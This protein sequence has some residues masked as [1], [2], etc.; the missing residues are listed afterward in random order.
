[1]A[2]LLDFIFGSGALKQAAQTGNP[3]AQQT[4][5]NPPSGSGNA[6]IDMAS[7]AQQQADRSLPKKKKALPA[8]TP[9]STLQK[10]LM[11]Q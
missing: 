4:T 7:L 1:M 9:S 8:A 2:S 11:K 3:P 10:N 6:G 5:V